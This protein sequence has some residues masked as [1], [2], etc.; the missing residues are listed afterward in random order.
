ML[1]K[2]DFDAALK[3]YINSFIGDDGTIYS[4]AADYGFM[5]PATGDCKQLVLS[6]LYKLKPVYESSDVDMNI[7]QNI[8]E[9]W[10]TL[11]K[12]STYNK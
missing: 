9:L 5:I 6:I 7:R 1:P 4:K 8:I 11:I 2:L 10:N 3:Q 12:Q